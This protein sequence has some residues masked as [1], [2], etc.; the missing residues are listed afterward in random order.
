MSK[1]DKHQIDEQTSIEIEMRARV[2]AA[3]QRMA[4][5]SEQDRDSY[6][7][8]IEF[9][10]DQVEVKRAIYHKDRTSEEIEQYSIRWDRITDE[11]TDSLKELLVWKPGEQVVHRFLENNPKFLIQA[12]SGGHGR[13]QISKHRLGAEFVPDFLI[14]ENSSIGLEWYAVEIESPQT[15]AHRKDGLQSQKLTHAI[16]QIRDWRKWIMNNL[17]Y[18]RRPREQDGLGLIGIDSRVAGLILIGR[19]SEYPERYNEF[20]RQMIDQERIIIHSYDW[21]VDLAATNRS[22]RLSTD[23]VGHG[24]SR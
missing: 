6:G 20:R 4:E 5:V 24:F 13:Y 11:D 1:T 3:R 17:D 8:Y 19:R 10:E 2:E 15:N 9:L 7:E 12:L 16:G 23:L 21:L 14:A 22:G 18:A